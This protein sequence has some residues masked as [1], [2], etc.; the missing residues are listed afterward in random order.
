VP[1]PVATRAYTIPDWYPGGKAMPADTDT[2]TA[3][4]AGD[5]PVPPACGAASRARLAHQVIRRRAWTRISGTT[6]ADSDETYWVGR[7]L[8]CEIERRHTEQY[9]LASGK[10]NVT[11]DT[12]T[13]L[14]VTRL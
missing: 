9:D 6:E 10:R 11:N 12:T 8:L 2:L 4:G 1:Y 13:T 14:G 5:T 3:S 7:I